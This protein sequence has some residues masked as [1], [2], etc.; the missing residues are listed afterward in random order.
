M[1]SDKE[2]KALEPKE[3]KKYLIADY[4]GLFVLVYP[5]G[6]KSF[7]FDYKDPKTRKLKRL[8]L[9]TYPTMSLKEARDERIKLQYNLRTNNSIEE[10]VSAN[11][12]FKEIC[13]K[14]FAQKNDVLPKTLITYK[15]RIETHCKSILDYK[16]ETIDKNDIL[17]IFERLK[18]TKKANLA[19][20]LFSDMNNIF[21]YALNRNLITQNPMVNIIKKD[22]IY[23]T[24]THHY[25]TIIEKD[26]IARLI[27]DILDTDAQ[28]NTKIATLMS[29]FTAQR[30]FSVRNAVWADIDLD[31]GIW[32]IAAGDM[33][34]KR[35]HIVHL[36]APLVRILKEYQ[37]FS[38]EGYLFSSLMSKSKIISDGTIRIMFRR[39]GYTKDEFTPH[40]F[41][42]MFSTICHEFRSEHGLSSDI[43][44]LCLAHIDKNAVRA[45]YNFASNLE[46]RKK[47][48]EW[49][50]QFLCKLEPRLAKFELEFI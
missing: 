39:M 32:E 20:R 45:S 13:E 14:Y 1:L 21:I 8:T 36:S 37:R 5:S 19:R 31:K 46:E 10:K 33:K 49:W 7:V 34:M 6:K 29:L 3:N 2:I 35:K 11:S 4:D 23:K 9:G 16:V 28:L 22:I 44:E 48:F 42:S 15:A 18:I 30:S 43:I 38:N 17:D 24:Q 27:S 12:N 25:A 47:L 41:R 26:K 50:G 40:G